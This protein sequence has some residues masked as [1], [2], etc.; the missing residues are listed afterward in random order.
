MQITRR[1]EMEPCS[2][3][4]NLRPCFFRER[5]Q[6]IWLGWQLGIIAAFATLDA[7]GAHFHRLN[8]T[9]PT[10][11]IPMTES[12]LLVGLGAGIFRNAALNV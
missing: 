1:F 2:L 3:Q 8:H 6:G 4:L 9:A 10:T 7:C 11:P 12:F 5:S